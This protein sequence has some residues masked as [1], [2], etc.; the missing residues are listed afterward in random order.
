VSGGNRK[1]EMAVKWSA[2][3]YVAIG[4]MRNHARGQG[5]RLD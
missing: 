4:S 1:L 2:R 3:R 5:W